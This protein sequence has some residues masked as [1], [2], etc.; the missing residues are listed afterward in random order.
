ME[1][2]N[3]KKVKGGRLGGLAT[4]KKHGKNHFKKIAEKG[5]ETIKE[6]YRQYYEK[7]S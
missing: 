1:E 3:P 7:L 4:L 6:I 2:K 5:R